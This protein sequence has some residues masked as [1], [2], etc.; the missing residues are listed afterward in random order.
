MKPQIKDAASVG[1]SLILL[2]TAMPSSAQ[3]QFTFT[4]VA[5]SSTR[6]PNGTGNFTNLDLPSL[7]SGEVAFSGSDNLQSG[8]FRGTGPSTL[9]VVA[10]PNTAIPNGTGNFAGV[11][12]PSISGGEV[13]FR[14]SDG[15]SQWGIYRGTGPTA[16]HL[17]ADTNTPIPGGTGNFV[18]LFEFVAPSLDGG[19]VAF[20]GSGGSSQSGIYRGTGPSALDLIADRNTSVPGGTGNFMSFGPPSLDA[21]EVAFFGLGSSQSGIYR[22]TGPSALHVIADTNTPVPGGMGNFTSFASP[23]LS[24]G[25]VAFAAL[26]GEGNSQ[27]GIYR[28]TGPSALHVI[29]DTNT[30]VPGG[31]GN[32]LFFGNIASLDGG[33]VAFLGFDADSVA[34]IYSTLG[35]SLEKVIAE[36]DLLHGKTV[37]SIDT[38]ALQLSGDQLVFGAL[39]SDG[40]KGIFIATAIQDPDGDGDG[41]PDADD[42]CPTL[43]NPDQTD[44][45]GDGFGDACVASNL[46]PS[47]DFGADPVI[48]EDVRIGREVAFGDNAEIGE[49]ATLDRDV[50][51]GDDVSIGAGSSVGRGVVLGNNVSMG[52]DVQVER[53]VVTGDNVAVGA[54]SAVGRDAMLGDGVTIGPNVVIER[55]TIIENGVAIGLACLPPASASAPPC[56]Q[57]GRDGV[58]RTNAVI[59]Q[60]VRLGRDVEVEAGCTVVAGSN[61]PRGAV[62]SCP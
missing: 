58:L 5:D 14:G 11:F 35:S 34:G 19:Q 13:A 57:I 18:D 9:A 54:G 44:A 61:L 15:D 16:L 39:F 48:G 1:L 28:G 31:T 29:A 45:N 23:T 27:S 38:S 24:A 55:G 53:D 6:I 33:K 56:V 59:E 22:G 42:N 50:V 2:T 3:T 17:V 20:A 25:E 10:D 46:P 26:F 7:D 51:A 40:S 52:P 4:K 36:D 12:A 21:G 32:F 49:G 41:V 62:V 37:A 47:A 8:I 43:A 30:P 60:S